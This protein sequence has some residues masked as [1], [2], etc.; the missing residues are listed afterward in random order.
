[1]RLIVVLQCTQTVLLITPGI[2]I[3]QVSTCVMRSAYVVFT[4]SS[5]GVGRKHECISTTIRIPF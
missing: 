4:C 1:M 5:L 3:I 2:S